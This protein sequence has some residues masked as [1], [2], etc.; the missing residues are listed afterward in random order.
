MLNPSQTLALD[1]I[2]AE[3]REGLALSE[4]AAPG[5]WHAAYDEGKWRVRGIARPGP[6]G[7]YLQRDA[8]FIAS[9]RTLCPKLA[10]A[11]IELVE[12]LHER[13]LA[14]CPFSARLLLNLISNWNKE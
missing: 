13:E 3:C 12:A 2:L 10:R 5:R 7:E 9:S 11:T 6:D 14:G 8:S 1:V 4:K